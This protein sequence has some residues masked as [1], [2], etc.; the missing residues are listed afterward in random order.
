MFE[1][2]LCSK[3]LQ[4]ILMSKSSYWEKRAKEDFGKGKTA[5]DNQM[6]TMDTYINE[7]KI[8]FKID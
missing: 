6:M 5:R 2:S 8:V 3:S 4:S 1:L 7:Y